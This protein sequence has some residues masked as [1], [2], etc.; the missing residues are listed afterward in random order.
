M[1]RVL[2]KLTLTDCI[3]F[4]SESLDK[5]V[6]PLIDGWGKF[7]LR[8]LLVDWKR[9]NI[10]LLSKV[11]DK[12][13]AIIS[14]VHRKGNEIFEGAHNKKEE[15]ISNVH[16]KGEELLTKKKQI[17]SSVQDKG[18][19]LLAKK[20]QILSNVHHTGEDFVEDVVDGAKKKIAELTS[21]VDSIKQKPHHDEA[22]L[23]FSRRRRATENLEALAD[24][25]ENEARIQ[26]L[27]EVDTKIVHD[28]E[29]LDIAFPALVAPLKPVV[30]AIDDAVEYYTLPE[31]GR[32]ILSWARENLSLRRLLRRP[33]VVSA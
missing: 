2:D 3:K 8:N 5:N 20:K 23:S 30:A 7:S 27:N 26:D 14:N 25:L 13:E 18:E 22:D 9:R 17:I 28:L 16:E 21:H 10:E 6:K 4:L 12:G 32:Q 15:I 1:G 11:H 33:V 31:L 29:G 24:L 19:E